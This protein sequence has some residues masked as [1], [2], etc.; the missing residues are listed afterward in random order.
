VDG[1]YLYHSD[2]ELRLRIP[3]FAVTTKTVHNEL[4]VPGDADFRV[5]R[6]LLQ[7]LPEIFENKRGVNHVLTTDARVTD[8]TEPLLIHTEIGRVDAAGTLDR[9][10]SGGNIYDAATDPSTLDPATQHVYE[11]RVRVC[12]PGPDAVNNLGLNFTLS[13]FSQLGNPV[14]ADVFGGAAAGRAVI[15]ADPLPSV[16]LNPGEVARV[17]YRVIFLDTA[18]GVELAAGAPV[19][20]TPVLEGVSAGAGTPLV[21]TGDVVGFNRSAELAPVDPDATPLLDALGAPVLPANLTAGDPFEIRIDLSAS[22]T[23]GGLMRTL[24]VTDIEVAINFDGADSVIHLSDSFFR[25]SGSSGLAF[26]S[27]RLDSDGGRAMP[28][29]LTQAADA[30]TVILTVQTEAGI[31]G[32]LTATCTAR[33]IDASTGVVSSQTSPSGNTTV[34]P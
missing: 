11:L 17:D 4:K 25:T 13:A 32:A 1:E 24:H 18:V 15:F 19:R 34:I 29:M 10:A 9:V 26:V 30:N 33:A 7:N 31:T 3:D 16:T 6:L 8:R 22:P 5:L 23:A 20:F 14:V 21:S 12:N 27:A 28:V 2:T